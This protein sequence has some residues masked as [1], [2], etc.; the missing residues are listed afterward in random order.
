[1]NIQAIVYEF[2]S[3]FTSCYCTTVQ[4]VVRKLLHELEFMIILTKLLITHCSYTSQC[5]QTVYEPS[6]IVRTGL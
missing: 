2:A 5:W 3:C 1:M 6:E 4:Y